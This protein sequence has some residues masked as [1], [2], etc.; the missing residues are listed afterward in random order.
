VDVNGLKLINDAFGHKTGDVLLEKVG[1]ILE[2]QCQ[3]NDVAARIGGDEFILLLPGC[4]EEK[5]GEI[6]EQIQI[7]SRRKKID[8]VI[9]SLSTGFAVKS[10]ESEKI[11]EIYKKAEDEMY[12]NKFY[13]TTNVRSKTIDLILSTLYEKNPREMLHSKRVGEICEA[14]AK[15]MNLD[16]NEVNQIRMAG[17][18]HDIGKIGIDEHILNKTDKLTSEEH[19]TMEKHVEKGWRILSSVNEYTKIAEYVLAHHERIDGKGYPQSRSGEKIPI[20]ARIIAIADSYDAMTS[21]RTYRDP[22][23][24]ENAIH[25]IVRCS[26]K[27]FDPAIACVF[28]DM[29]SEKEI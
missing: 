15:R 12:R 18:M 14:V 22:F 29:L 25:E 28:I 26:G 16:V 24:K 9:F 27:Q 6:T 11:E 7:A 8:N 2:K 3:K 5:A 17:L 1:G 13:E 10:K 4:G 19:M 21:M 20:G 23:T